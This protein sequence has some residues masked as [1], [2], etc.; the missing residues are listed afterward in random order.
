VHQG[1]LTFAKKHRGWITGQVLEVG[2]FNVNGSVRDVLPITIGIDMREGNGVDVV[3]SA[4]D[5]VDHFGAES[6]DSVVSCDALEHIE[7]WKTALTQMWTVLKPK[8]CLL[9][10]MANPEKGR[11]AYPDDYWRFPMEDFKK[12]FGEN[13]IVAEFYQNPSMGCCVVKTGDLNLNV[14]PQKVP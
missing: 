10:T 1:I 13:K 6:F 4:Y 14:V 9:L 8:G 2:S 3:L 5:L 12:L 11:H 7:D